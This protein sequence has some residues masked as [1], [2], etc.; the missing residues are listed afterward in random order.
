MPGNETKL[1]SLSNSRCWAHAAA[2]AD[3]GKMSAL[4]LIVATGN[5]ANLLFHRFRYR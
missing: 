5:V 1:A 3:P 2:N 4:V